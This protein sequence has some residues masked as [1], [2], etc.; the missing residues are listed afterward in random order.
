MP[1]ASEP[2]EVTL[3][4]RRIEGLE[5]EIQLRIKEKKDVC[6]VIGV[7]WQRVTNLGLAVSNA[8]AAAQI[9]HPAEEDDT[10]SIQSPGREDG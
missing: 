5:Q 2:L 10:G 6:D 7:D 3:L 8:V 9:P 1:E 4:R